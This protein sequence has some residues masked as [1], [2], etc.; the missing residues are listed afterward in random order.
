VDGKRDFED[1]T[2]ISYGMA[3]FLCAEKIIRPDPRD[4]ACSKSM[5]LGAKL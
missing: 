5:G 2:R 1:S 3:G 4:P